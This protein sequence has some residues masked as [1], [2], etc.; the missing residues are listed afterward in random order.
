M[1]GCLLITKISGIRL[2]SARSLGVPA[3]VM[4]VS[5]AQ[6]QFEMLAKVPGVKG[7][8]SS[9]EEERG[10]STVQVV[11]ES[12][13]AARGAEEAIAESGLKLVASWRKQATLEEVFVALVGRGFKERE[14]EDVG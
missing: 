11:V 5:P 2:R 14:E 12:D 7:F 1:T 4:E 10:L 8:T 13:S 3:L 6:E 9:T